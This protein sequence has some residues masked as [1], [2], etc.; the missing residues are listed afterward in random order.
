LEQPRTA[1]TSLA[2][3]LIGI[4]V[5]GC[6]TSPRSSSPFIIRKGDGPIHAGHVAPMPHA[7]KLR[8][9]EAHRAAVAKRAAEKPVEVAS[10]ERLDPQLR[11]VLA[12][13]GRSESAQAHLEVAWRYWGVGVYDAAYDHYSE[14]IRIDPKNASAWEGRARVWRHWH[15]TEPALSD[16]HRAIFYAPGR[17]DLRNTLGTILELGGQCAEASQAY[18]AALKLEPT[19]M[20]AKAN[21]DRLACGRS[22]APSGTVRP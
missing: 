10:I 14:A 12:A 8:L 1:A 5:S 18:A 19:A 2:L 11:D 15:M 13:L 20:W 3:L 9:D 17:A 16:V 4:A 22:I 6:V 21:L 7:A